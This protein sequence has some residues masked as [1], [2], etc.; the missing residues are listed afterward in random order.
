MIFTIYA[1]G[2]QLHFIILVLLLL[3]NF[4]MFILDSGKNILEELVF[5][6]AA[7]LLWPIATPYIMYMDYQMRRGMKIDG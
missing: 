7:I 6:G 3:L 2:V 5:A 4:K 1:W